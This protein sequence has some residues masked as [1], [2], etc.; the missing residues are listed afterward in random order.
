MSRY[1]ILDLKRK[2]GSWINYTN[3]VHI[4]YMYK[5]TYNKWLQ[6]SSIVGT[7]IITYINLRNDK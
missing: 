7:T 3:S 2:R 6:V 4:I 5:P 1:F